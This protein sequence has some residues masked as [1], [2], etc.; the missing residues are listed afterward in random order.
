LK[1]KKIGKNW[2]NERKHFALKYWYYSILISYI[3]IG[4]VVLLKG[5]VSRDLHICFLY[6]LIDLNFLHLIEPFVCFLN[7]V[8]VSNFSIF[9]SQRSEL[10]L[11]FTSTPGI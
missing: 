9:A 3:H 2:T 8:F 6:Q 5:M 7:F 10:T 11:G 1:K 4:T